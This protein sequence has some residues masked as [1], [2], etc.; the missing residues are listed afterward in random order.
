MS[1]DTYIESRDTHMYLSKDT[2]IEYRDTHICF[3]DTY[4]YIESRDTHIC[5]K[6]TYIESRDAHICFKETYIESR[7]THICLNIGILGLEIHIFVLKIQFPL[8]YSCIQRMPVTISVL[9]AGLI[10]RSAGAL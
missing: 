7:D 10:V 5:F 6:V 8:L 1:K 3:K 2:Y 9:S 4:E